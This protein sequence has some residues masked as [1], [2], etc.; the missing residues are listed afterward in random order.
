MSSSGS[1]TIGIQNIKGF[2]ALLR[3]HTTVIFSD[4]QWLTNRAVGRRKYGVIT[5]LFGVSCVLFPRILSRLKY[6]R[7]GNDVHD[8]A[9]RKNRGRPSSPA[10]RVVSPLPAGVR[11]HLQPLRHCPHASLAERDYH[12]LLPHQ[13]AAAPALFLSKDLEEG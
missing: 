12:D 8:H 4:S 2:A 1:G 11:E 7:C 10:R 3:A 6:N 13:G 5:M 9:E